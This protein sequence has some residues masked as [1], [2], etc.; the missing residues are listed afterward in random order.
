MTT[1][2]NSTIQWF[3][4]SVV[5]LTSAL[6]LVLEIVAGR[7]LAPYIG[8]SLY[9]WTSIIGV[10][11]A[12]LSLGNW[13]GGKLADRS[14]G[15]MTVGS[16]LIAGAI[17]SL[18]ILPLLMWTAGTIQQQSVS[19]VSA[20]FIFVLVLFFIPAALL[21]I[22]SPLLTTLCLELDNRPG[23]IVGRMH[24]LGAIGSI[25]GTFITGY[26][27]VQW[28]G[29]RTI[30]VTVAGLLFIMGLLFLINTAR[31][32]IISIIGVVVLTTVAAYTYRNQGLASP[33]EIESNYYCLRVADEFDGSNHLYARTLVLD[34]MVHSTNVKDNPSELW[35]PYIQAMDTLIHSHFSTPDKLSYFFAGGGAYT[36]P[37]SIN[38]RYPEAQIDVSE[39]D[40]AVTRLAQQKLFLDTKGL[41]IH[42][43]DTRTV[44]RKF[45]D[46]SFDVAITDVFHDVGIPYHLTTLEY[47][48]LSARKLKPGGLY[49]LN[50]VDLFPSNRLVQ[51]MFRTLKQEFEYV[52]VW[53]EN[54][55][56]K[57][58]RLTFVLAASDTAF[59]VPQVSSA[60]GIARTWFDIGDFIGQ[61]AEQYQ[62]PVLT[63]NFAP[64]ERLLHKLLTTRA[65]T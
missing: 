14:A 9:T 15:H 50:V 25:V 46:Q 41:N 28:L 47:H 63:D 48:R 53:I 51:A 30:I 62:S 65:G 1:M 18:A 26:W 52:G 59:V 23:T 17:M 8:V 36:H 37:R 58:T 7:L 44:L 24:A 54:P 56:D 19:L 40:P 20:S 29:T 39:I 35:T 21:G 34:H 38:Y 33:C 5:F 57:E 27:L 11:L 60:S 3:Y 32:R 61:Q 43:A 4:A 12:G 45:E 2:N 64:V 16:V 13:I 42:H 31:G 49:L 6:L 55:P 22:I 10:I